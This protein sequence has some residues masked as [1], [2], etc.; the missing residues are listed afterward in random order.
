MFKV[1]G[2]KYQERP[3]RK[4]IPNK[5]KF[6]GNRS[7]KGQRETAPAPLSFEQWPVTCFGFFGGWVGLGWVRFG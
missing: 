5:M 4:W 2:K 7:L 6:G 3:G 1:G